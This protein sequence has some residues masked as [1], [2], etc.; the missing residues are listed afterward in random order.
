MDVTGFTWKTLS[1]KLLAEK[2]DVKA[3]KILVY[4]LL[5]AGYAVDKVYP[6]IIDDIIK[7]W[8]NSALMV[9]CR[10]PSRL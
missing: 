6:V 8:M 4:L 9:S 7:A 1:E 10:K 3:A 2:K 5:T